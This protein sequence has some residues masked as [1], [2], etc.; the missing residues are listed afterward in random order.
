MPIPAMA[1]VVAGLT[2][3]CLTGDVFN[4]YVFLEISA[5]AAYALLAV[6]DRAGAVAVF[7][8]LIIGAVGGGFYLLGVAY[9][10]FSTGTL[11]MADLAV[12]SRSWWS[13]GRSSPPRP[14][15][16]SGWPSRWPSSPSTSGSRTSTR[17]PRRR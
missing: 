10:Y 8:Y 4:L 6:G 11:N 2:G 9:L 3:M 14:S 12:L 7:R 1:L 15:W 13:P 16:S 17:T 5:L